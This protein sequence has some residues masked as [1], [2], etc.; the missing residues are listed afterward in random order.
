MAF[1]W[2]LPSAVEAGTAGVDLE[3]VGVDAEGVVELEELVRDGF[4]GGP[5]TVA[6]GAVAVGAGGDT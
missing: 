5:E 6:V 1:K 3:V 4:H 2:N